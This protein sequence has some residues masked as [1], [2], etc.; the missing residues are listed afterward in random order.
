MHTQLL[1][2]NN[3]NNRIALEIIRVYSCQSSWKPSTLW[4]A[5]ICIYFQLI[6]SRCIRIELN[7]DKYKNISIHLNRPSPL[8]RSISNELQEILKITLDK[9]I[10]INER[11]QRWCWFDGQLPRCIENWWTKKIHLQLFM[12]KKK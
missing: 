12:K 8:Y 6:L 7:S 10:F 3:N 9:F 1:H 2:W 5:Y 11:G 4:S